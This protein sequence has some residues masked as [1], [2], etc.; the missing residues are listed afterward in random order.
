MAKWK[1]IKETLNISTEDKLIIDL[2]VK[3]VAARQD[4]GLTQ[5]ELASKVG[6]SQPQIA[7]IENL[8]TMPQIDT[9]MKLIVALNLGFSITTPNKIK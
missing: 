9:L 6:M 7:K 1:D 3:I 8:D 5:A 2:M 4:Q